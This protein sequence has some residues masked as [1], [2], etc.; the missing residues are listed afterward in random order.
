[1][2]F[3]RGVFSD[4][5]VIAEYDE[6][7]GDR[8]L[9]LQKGEIWVCDSANEISVGYLRVS[10]DHFFAWP[11]VSYLCVQEKHR[12]QG[13]A[14]G[15]LQSLREEMTFSRLYVST[16]ENNH[17]MRSLLKKLDADPIGHI[18]QLNFDDERELIFRLL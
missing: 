11:F 17:A 13:V 10:S 5:P 1:M 18:D 3:R 14:S 7:I 4:Y 6:F 16:E 2:K 12:R 9:D 15:L 8:R